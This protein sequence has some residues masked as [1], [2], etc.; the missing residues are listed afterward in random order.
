MEIIFLNYEEWEFFIKSHLFLSHFTTLQAYIFCSFPRNLILEFWD[1]RNS[2]SGNNSVLKVILMTHL[3]T[4][5]PLPVGPSF[6]E[7]FPSKSSTHP[8]LPLPSV[9]P[10][11]LHSTARS[12]C[13]KVEGWEIGSL[14][15]IPQF[16]KLH[17]S[18]SFC[19]T[20]GRWLH[21]ILCSLVFLL[22]ILSFFVFVYLVICF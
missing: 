2:F 10:S 15:R 17:S 14:N 4:C 11:I 3:L 5:P 18:V 9:C 6:Q 21:F 13:L 7:V 19:C 12:L 22:W 1:S 20:V 16:L 8:P